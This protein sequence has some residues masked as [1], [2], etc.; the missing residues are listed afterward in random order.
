MPAV[1]YCVLVVSVGFF[2]GR[3]LSSQKCSSTIQIHR[4]T[5]G[6]T[7]HMMGCDTSFECYLF[8]VE[9]F[10]DCEIRPDTLIKYYFVCGVLYVSGRLATWLSL[11]SAK[12]V[13]FFF[14]EWR[15]YSCQVCVCVCWKCLYLSLVVTWS[16]SARHLTDLMEIINNAIAIKFLLS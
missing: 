5:G 8:N 6:R 10:M 12:F 4:A 13:F 11:W 16:V 1:L 15:Y 9:H 3:K 14:T 7:K 2:S